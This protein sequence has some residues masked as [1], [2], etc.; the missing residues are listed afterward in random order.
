M[1]SYTGKK[2]D[3]LWHSPEDLPEDVINDMMKSLLNESLADCGK[4]GL[5][6]FYEANPAPAVSRPSE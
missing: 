3:P 1:C 6:P 4:V 2:D 5:A